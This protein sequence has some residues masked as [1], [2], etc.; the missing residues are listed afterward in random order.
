MKVFSVKNNNSNNFK[1]MATI[2]P[3]RKINNAKDA[4]AQWEVLKHPKF[5]NIFQE[6]EFATKQMLDEN[7]AIREHNYSFLDELKCDAEK[8]KFIEHFKHFTGFP[9]LKAS[10][11]RMVAEFRRTLA[12]AAAMLGAS[13]KDVLMLGYDRFCSVGLGTALPG[14]DLDKGFAVVKGEDTC[15]IQKEEEYSNNYK[16][17]IWENIDNRIMS[18]NHCAAYPNIIT[19]NE[20]LMKLGKFDRL[21]GNLINNK[22]Y[23]IFQAEIKNN[24]NP[25]AAAKYNIWLSKRLNDADKVE[26]KNFAYVVEAIRDGKCET[27]NIDDLVRLYTNMNSSG[28]AMCSN[29]AQTHAMSKKYQDN[30]HGV[31]KPKL[32]ARLDIE[33]FF[34]SWNI[35]KQFELVKDVIRSMSGDNKNPEFN[36]LFDSKADMHRLLINDILS[37]KIDCSFEFPQEG[38]ER[39][40]LMFKNPADIETYGNLDLYSRD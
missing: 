24:P 8:K 9:I 7:K 26:A 27:G 15:D 13:D 25:V 40:H 29:I 21:S 10:S 14:S 3:T 1:G 2:A 28:F 22:T 11:Q 32:K 39:I 19:E 36:I 17:Q 18:V 16:A 37:G 5:T 23:E 33:K 20:L 31:M 6:A 34:D 4:I 38:K 35:G 12:V 30:P